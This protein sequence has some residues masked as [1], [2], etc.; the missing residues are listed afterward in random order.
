MSVCTITGFSD[1]DNFVVVNDIPYF[2][3]DGTSYRNVSLNMFPLEAMCDIMMIEECMKNMKK[4]VN[5]P[6]MYT[7]HNFKNH[8]QV[9][10]E[11][12]DSDDSSVSSENKRRAN[13]K[14]KIALMKKT[15]QLKKNVAKK[16][17]YKDKLFNQNEMLHNPYFMDSKLEEYA[18]MELEEYIRMKEDYAEFLEEERLEMEMRRAEEE[19][20][21]EWSL[22]SDRDYYDDYYDDIDDYFDY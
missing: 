15:R 9:Y 8:S 11:K 20:Y 6:G 18:R 5:S 13:L 19:A 3:V 17:G 2:K 7:T 12:Y 21:A 22:R 14:R 1:A 10:E 16:N 4:Y